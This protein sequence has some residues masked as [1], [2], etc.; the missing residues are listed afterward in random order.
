M[1]GL[2][3]P[4]AAAAVLAPVL[5]PNGPLS[6]PKLCAAVAPV[7][8]PM[9]MLQ[10]AA[11]AVLFH[12][13][14]VAPAAADP[15][16]A[17]H[18]SLLVCAL[19]AMGWAML[20]SSDPCHKLSAVAGVPAA[21]PCLL[22]CNLATQQAPSGKEDL[23]RTRMEAQLCNIWDSSRGHAC[24]ICCLLDRSCS[25]A[26]GSNLLGQSSIFMRA[27][28][29]LSSCLLQTVLACCQNVEY[30]NLAKT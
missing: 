10:S 17:C 28:R 20:A 6:P 16:N 21:A 4:S 23:S 8:L 15:A 5:L 1:S 2:H 22:C 18:C 14:G 19:E 12:A 26:A 13:A 3:L 27:G 30:C 29:V 11:A 9:A 25:H 24:C 7:A